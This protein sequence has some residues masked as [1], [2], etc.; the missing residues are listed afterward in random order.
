MAYDYAG[1]HYVASPS[2]HMRVGRHNAPTVN[3]FEVTPPKGAILF[4]G[5]K[6]FINGWKR[7]DYGYDKVEA[8]AFFLNQALLKR[9]E[10]PAWAYEIIGDTLTFSLGGSVYGLESLLDYSEGSRAR[11]ADL[12]ALASSP[13]LPDFMRGYILGNVVYLPQV[14]CLPDSGLSNEDME[15]YASAYAESFQ[16]VLDLGAF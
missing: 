16:D 4:N 8:I 13:A 15:E 14:D 10:L 5:D 11:M 6:F 7:S 3:L 2:E 1:G 12:L 9:K